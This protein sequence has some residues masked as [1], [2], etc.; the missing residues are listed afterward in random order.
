MIIKKIELENFMCYSGNNVFEFNEGLNLIIGD[1]GGGKSKLY[2]AFYWVLYDEIFVP[3]LKEFQNTSI[4]KRKLVSDK[5]IQEHIDGS[6]RTF[7]RITFHNLENEEAYVFKREYYVSKLN[8]VLKGSPQS[9]LT[10]IYK[11]LSYLTGKQLVGEQEIRDAKEKILPSRN[12]DYLWFQG[13]QVE[14]IIDFNKQDSLTKAI[15]VLSSITRYDELN[16][17]AVT[18]LSAATLEYDAKRRLLT[19]DIEKCDLLEGQKKD[20]EKNIQKLDENLIEIN[21]NLSRTERRC[22]ELLSKITDAKKVS[23]LKER[24]N[25]IVQALNNLRDSYKDEEVSFHKKMFRNKW[26]IQGTEKLQEKYANLYDKYDKDKLK[27]IA[28]K[29]S[30]LELENK[31]ESIIKT[32]LPFNVPEPIYVERMLEQEKCLVCDRDA[33]KDSIAWLKI[34]ELIARSDGQKPIDSITCFNFY[35][36]FKHLYINGL[37]LRGRIK[38]IKEDINSCLIKRSNIKSKIKALNNDH[39]NIDIEITKLLADT[40]LTSEEAEN[41][42]SEYSISKRREKEYQEKQ[43]SIKNDIDRLDRALSDINEKL[44]LLIT[45]EF[46]LWLAEKK[47]ILSDFKSLCSSTRERVFATLISR[48][49]TEAN[50]HYKSMTSIRLAAGNPAPTGKIKLEKLPNGNFMPEIIDDFGTP[51]SGFNTSNL[52]L[53]KLATIMA[54]ISINSADGVIDKYTLI[55]DAPTSVFGEDYTIGFC[56]TVSNVYK[57][58]IIMSKE[59]YYN[60]RLKEELLS[61]DEINLGK[62]FIIEPTSTERSKLSIKINSLSINGN[63]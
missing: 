42:I 35:D 37:T 26:V 17:I 2:D 5:A 46:P 45:G 11:E 18:A 60:E 44:K 6:I 53:V 3:E 48:L 20:I 4:V 22:E 1:N 34:K 27:I 55:S 23:E 8:G 10:V 30:E 43:N 32:R 40:S 19:K 50:K 9:E 51:L 58:S 31:L 15:N 14:S 52:I 38:D 62:V 25:G 16:S 54:I 61:N 56:K 13:E 7:V 59:F 36:D 12:K 49:E 21:K 63:S 24:R 47:S 39:D 29:E 33:P 28:K 57:Q 41:I